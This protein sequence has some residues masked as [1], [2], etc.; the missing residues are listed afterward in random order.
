MVAEDQNQRI[1]KVITLY[2]QGEFGLP[3]FMATHLSAVVESFHSKLE[4]STLWRR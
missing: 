3:G 2:S 1:T 4:M